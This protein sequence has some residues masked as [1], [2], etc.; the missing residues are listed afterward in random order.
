[1]GDNGRRL[2]SAAIRATVTTTKAR[3]SRAI[4]CLGRPLASGGAQVWNKVLL[5]E[6]QEHLQGWARF[7]C[8][9]RAGVLFAVQALPLPPVLFRCEIPSGATAAIAPLPASEMVAPNERPCV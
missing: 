6:H 5:T 7:G 4:L 8:A 2:T 9:Y 1:M 3:S